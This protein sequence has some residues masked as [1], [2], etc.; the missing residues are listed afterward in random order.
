MAAISK[1]V[2][3]RLYPAAGDGADDA[4]DAAQHNKQHG[5]KPTRRARRGCLV[6][7]CV[8]LPPRVSL[9]FSGT[10]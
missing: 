4:D 5:K 7:G 10:G 6:A 8:Y 1:S 2:S 3:H 9:G